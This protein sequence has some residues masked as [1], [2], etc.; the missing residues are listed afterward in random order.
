MMDMF[1]QAQG[2]E[3]TKA[4]SPLSS[5]KVDRIQG[6]SLSQEWEFRSNYFEEGAAEGLGN[7]EKSN[8]GDG[9]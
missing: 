1:G 3:D 5:L 6:R 4:K 2:K 7:M 8:D 9:K